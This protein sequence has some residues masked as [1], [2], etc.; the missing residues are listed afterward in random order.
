MKESIALFLKKLNGLRGYVEDVLM[1]RKRYF[2]SL[3]NVSF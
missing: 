1:V 3:L 2:F